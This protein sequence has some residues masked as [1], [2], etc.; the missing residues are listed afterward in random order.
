M[1][2]A[3]LCRPC[4]S[5]LSTLLLL[6]LAAC[7]GDETTQSVTADGSGAGSGGAAPE[8]C[9]LDGVSSASCPARPQGSLPEACAS[10]RVFESSGFALGTGPC[11]PVMP[12]LTDWECPEGWQ[13]VPGFGPGSAAAG[14]PEGMAPFTSCEPPTTATNCP[15]GTIALPGDAVCRP[16]GTPCPSAS[17]RWSSEALLRELAP[18]YAGPIVY[19][20]PDGVAENDGS[21]SSPLPLGS[22]AV[23]AATGGILALALGEYPA[24]IRIDRKVALLG[25]CVTGTRV[26]SSA[27]YV[28]DAG[29]IDLVGGGLALVRDLTLS[30]TRPGIT[31]NGRVTGSHTLSSISMQATTGRGLLVSIPQQ[32]FATDLRIDDTQPDPDGKYGRGIE[33][34]AGARLSL[35]GASLSGNRRTGILMLDAGTTIDA[36]NLVI[37]ATQPNAS[38]QLFGRGLDIEDGA[39][40]TL[41]R[42][43]LRGA[44]DAGIYISGNGTRMEAEAL[45]VEDT[46]PLASNGGFGRGIAVSDGGQLTLRGAMVRRNR[47]AGILVTGQGSALTARYLQVEATLPQEVDLAGGAGL[48]A[49]GGANASISDAVFRDNLE[50]GIALYDAGTELRLERTLVQGTNPS[51]GPEPYASG[52]YVGGGTTAALRDAVLLSNVGAGLNVYGAESV[53]TAER[54]LAEESAPYPSDGRYGFGVEVGD[55]ARLTLQDSTLRRNHSAGLLINDPGTEVEATSLLIEETRSRQSDGGGGAGAELY[56]GA[57]LSLT[58]TMLRGN[59][60]VGLIVSGAAS[61]VEAAQLIIADTQPNTRAGELGLGAA[62]SAEAVVTLQDAVL[63]RNHD[64]G[65]ILHDPNTRVTATRTVI[66][67]TAPRPSAERGGW[68][69]IALFGAALDLEDATFLGNHEVGLAA[70][71]PGT[72]I[73]ANRLAA[74]ETLVRL[75]D[76]SL[77]DGMLV[78]WGAALDGQNLSLARNARAGLFVTGNAPLLTIV[79]LQA[80]GNDIGINVTESDRSLDAVV[81]GIQSSTYLNNRIDLGTE[82]LPIPDPLEA[83]QSTLLL[84]P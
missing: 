8:S 49:A 19:V 80:E 32:V 1:L 67:E 83:T 11:E 66:Q 79:G 57:T 43:V 71:D 6:G 5:L 51:A 36:E 59:H 62:I 9:W 44:H 50:S 74:H 38:D 4:R 39:S 77:G 58:S 15:E 26:T 34:G 23:R 61:T 68:G 24:G 60:A 69:A 31:V 70:A 82:S 21:R 54:L 22:A 64:I 37:S 14:V 13:S 65:L 42:A 45:L 41:R 53:A 25:A 3:P 47:L 48:V 28:S 56:G 27:G 20:A 29:V 35:D 18:G 7:G 72:S 75:S 12:T 78:G 16:M 84:S 76:S 17:E 52:I 46:Q 33:L 55:T 63:E 40:G 2:T 30:G 73:T 10:G 81:E